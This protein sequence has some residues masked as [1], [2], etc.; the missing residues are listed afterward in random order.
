MKIL[1]V[2]DSYP[3]EIRSASHLM[4]ELAQ[5]LHDRQHSVTVLTCYPRYN[6]ADGS[7]I[8]NLKPV[9]NEDSIRVV[10]VH[11]PAHHKVNFFIRG[12]SQLAM[13]YL[14]WKKAKAQLQDGVD[15][16]IVYS[17]P[18]TL[19]QVGKFV[20][21]RFKARFIFNVQDIFPQ[22]A[23]DLGVL[24]NPVIIRFF[25]MIEAA[26][27]RN[28]DVVT[29]HSEG[30]RDFL[31]KSGKVSS[32][33]LITLHN[34]INVESYEAPEH[35]GP[36]RE[37]L[38]LA[39][40]FVIFFGGVMGPSQGLDLVIEAA[41]QIRD[42]PEIVFLLVG[43]GTEK[44]RLVDLA[45]RYALKNV[46]F[47]P[48]ISKDDYESLLKEIDVGLV[49]LSSKNKTPVV[50]GK[51][52]SYMASGVPVLAFLNRESDGHKIIRDAGCGYSV[53]A[54]GSSEAAAVILK[55]YGEKDRLRELGESGYHYAASRFSKKSCVDDLEK[56]LN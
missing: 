30:N 20:K 35:S 26:A 25:E 9:V 52:L 10:R 38:G 3:P 23:I 19:W 11:T 8:P 40:K 13:P 18:L 32:D 55:M 47:H 14:F 44:Q 33:K 16:V 48:F 4:K 56:V 39:G 34:W 54:G 49:C 5:E 45:S 22:N 15:A 28:A 50:P 43:D 27:Y 12:F 17:P 42:N 7:N 36:F 1:L 46:V 31:L 21:N 53:V 2:T 41:R 24:T 51:I 37:K 29:V 6:L